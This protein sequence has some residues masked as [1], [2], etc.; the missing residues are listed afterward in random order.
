MNFPQLPR[1]LVRIESSQQEEEIWQ[2]DWK[3]FCCQDTGRVQSHLVRLVIPD[4]DDSHDGIPICQVPSCNHNSRWLNFGNNNLD[5]R[6]IP[7][8]CQQ[9]DMYNREDW[10][11]TV[12]RKVINLQELAKKKAMSGVS[13][14]TDYDNRE[15]Q[16]RS[17]EIE[18]ITSE[19]WAAMAHAYQFGK[20]DE[21]DEA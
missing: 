19:Q 1:Q 14:R 18:A 11:L 7:A 4:Y 12:E 8:I 3:C 2:P 15:V 16:Q 10:R 6:F 17:S 20:K 5:M 21:D 13:D 9:L